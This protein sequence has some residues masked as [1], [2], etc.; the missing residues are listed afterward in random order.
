[1]GSLSYNHKTFDFDD[2]ILTHLQ[3][4]IVRKLRRGE[5]FL[6]SWKH[7]AQ[8]GG[9][10]S[11]IWVHPS[12]PLLFTFAGGRSPTVNLVWLAQLS[13]SADGPHGLVVT[14]EDLAH[15]SGLPAQG[16]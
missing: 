15:G 1:V 7:T 10:R 16:R 2:R 3:I 11:S 8:M 12:V 5:S 4:V 14:G 6:V 9:G 13:L